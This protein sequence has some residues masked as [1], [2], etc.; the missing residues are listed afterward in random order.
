MN[1]LITGGAGFIGSHLSENLNDDK[2]VKKIY[3][4]DNLSSGSKKNI[5]RILK[6]KKIK[7]IKQDI[8]NINKIK[9]YFRDISTVFHLAGLVDV[10]YSIKNPIEY[11]KNNLLGTLNILECMKF[12]NVKKIIFAASSSCY[13]NAGKKSISETQKIEPES[14]YAYTKNSAEELIKLFS[15]MNKINFISLRL[16]NVYGPR[17]KMTGNY[18]SVISIFLNQKK[19]QRPLTIVGDGNQSRDFVHVEDV[20]E[21]FKKAGFKKIKNKIFNIG[22]G[23]SVTINKI[24][25]IFGGKKKFIPKRIGDLK[26]S[27]AKIF[28]VKKDLKWIPKKN[29]VNS[30]Q[31]LIDELY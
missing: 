21:V 12:H 31:E 14:P 16:F 28:K 6:G 24:A 13:G 18:A 26:F 23:K 4:I 29:L 27:K 17:A 5:S 22:T 19:N 3:I 1:I 20:V 9:K 11:F 7:F 10:T 25:K 8:R 30:I 15:K 2:R